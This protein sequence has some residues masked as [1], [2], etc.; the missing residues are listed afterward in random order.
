MFALGRKGEETALLSLKEA[1][2]TDRLADFIAQEE[3]RGVGPANRADLGRAI[4][5]M[6]KS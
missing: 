2:E 3:E 1:L 5:R 4:S 6:I